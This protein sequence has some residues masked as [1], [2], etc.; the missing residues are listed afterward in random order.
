MSRNGGWNGPDT[1]G[2]VEHQY[3]A[4]LEAVELNLIFEKECDNSTAKQ[5]GRHQTANDVRATK[6][7]RYLP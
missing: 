6:L 4:P 5:P 1:S 7:S 2:K 3:H